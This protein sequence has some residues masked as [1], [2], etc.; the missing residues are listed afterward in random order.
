MMDEI[1]KPCCICQDLFTVID[2]SSAET[3]NVCK[4]C[5]DRLQ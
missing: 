5:R 2:V 1:V 3:R 4:E